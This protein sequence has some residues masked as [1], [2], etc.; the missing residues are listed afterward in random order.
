MR[1]SHKIISFV[2]SFL[3]VLAFLA[4]STASTEQGTQ[5]TPHSG[6]DTDF[7]VSPFKGP[8][9]APV[10]IAIFSCFQ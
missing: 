3:I 4:H 8:A 5:K 7:F 6:P 2:L 1:C 10:E 9:E